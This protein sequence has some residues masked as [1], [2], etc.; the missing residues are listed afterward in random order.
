MHSHEYKNPSEFANKTVCIIGASHSGEDIAREVGLNCTKVYL[1]AKAHTVTG[2][3]SPF[4]EKMNIYRIKGTID[5]ISSQKI[6][7]KSEN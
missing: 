6:Y 5:R 3:K 7:I 1:L 4:G 2:D